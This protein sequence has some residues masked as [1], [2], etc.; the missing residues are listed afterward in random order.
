MVA[1]TSGLMPFAKDAAVPAVPHRKAA[2]STDKK[3]V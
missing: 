2:N 1:I 3:P